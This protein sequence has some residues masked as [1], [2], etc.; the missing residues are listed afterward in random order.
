MKHTHAALE[1][2]KSEVADV[3]RA[4]EDERSQ[5]SAAVARAAAAAATAAAAAAEVEH[6]QHAA[7]LAEDEL[8]ATTAAADRARDGHL[9]ALR[10]VKAAAAAAATAAAARATA[11]EAALHRRA[12]RAVK[13]E[14][15][16][17]SAYKEQA[18]TAHTKFVDVR[19]ALA[20][21]VLHSTGGSASSERVLELAKALEKTRIR[22][23]TTTA[24]TANANV[25]ASTAGGAT[26]AASQSP[27]QYGRSGVV[28]RDEGS[29]GFGNA[30]TAAY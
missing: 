17:G 27:G 22:D 15:K 19:R 7:A 20:A 25:N 30:S 4:L 3:H 23:P 26:A 1:R 24:T 28:V 9:A 10:Q 5:H 12:K 8:R 2:A 16:R 29:A 13:R 6:A 21:H 11:N 14:R 18:L